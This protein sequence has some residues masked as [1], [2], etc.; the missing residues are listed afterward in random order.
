MDKGAAE[1][2]ESRPRSV[3]SE[4]WASLGA[5]WRDAV[6]YQ[7]FLFW[8]AVA[9][10]ASAAVHGAVFLLGDR[11]W[12]GPLSWRKP[13]LFSFSFAAVSASIAWVMT[14]LAK[15]RRYGWPLAI[16]FAS[17]S[18]GETA[19][20]AMQAWR[21]RGPPTSMTGRRSTKGCSSRWVGCSPGLQRWS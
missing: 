6:P 17:A 12:E 19:L 2:T 8:L 1:V 5:Y 18:V 20:I 21:G 16:A 3:G 7:R 9:F 10:L 4:M 13:L 15:R 14:F 11:A